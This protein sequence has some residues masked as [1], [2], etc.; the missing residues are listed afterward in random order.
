MLKKIVIAGLAAAAALLAEATPAQQEIESAKSVVQRNP[1]D[2]G[3]QSRL[4]MAYSKRAR[5]T[6]DPQF[7][8]QAMATIARVLEIS[9]DNYEAL[10][11]KAWTL[12]GQHEFAQAAELAEALNRRAPDDVMVYGFLTDAYVELGRYEEALESAQWML[13]MRPGAVAGLTRAAYIREIYGYI[14]GAVELMQ[15]AFDRSPYNEREDLAW[16]QVHIAHLRRLQKDFDAAEAHIDKALTFFPGYHY[17]LAER[18]RLRMAQG[19]YEEAAAAFDERYQLASH[20]ENLFDYAEALKLAG[21]DA[22]AA[23]MFSH[24]EQ[25]AVSESDSWD[26]ANRELIAYYVDYADRP[27]E[28]LQIAARDFGRRQ[29]VFTRASYAWALFHAGQQDEARSQI[30]QV[31]QLGVVDPRIFRYAEAMGVARPPRGLAQAR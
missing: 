19:R 25:A 23:E 27:L 18:G 2:A 17:A 13:D 7:Y 15:Q 3:A 21:Q 24:F 16:I 6:G 4:A 1:E 10:R 26:N 5:E 28:A 20:P 29:D 8:A 9:P 30:R 14:D 11:A 31:L 12:L 22:E